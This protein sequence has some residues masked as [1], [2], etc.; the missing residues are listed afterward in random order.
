MNKMRSIVVVFLSLLMLQSCVVEQDY[1]V[2]ADHSGRFNLSMDISGMAALSQDSSMSK[3]LSEEDLSKMTANFEK[4]AGLTNIHA[5][6]ENFK[7]STGFDFNNFDAIKNLGKQDENIFGGLIFFSG[8]K[9]KVTIDFNRKSIMQSL[10][11]L[12][13]GNIEQMNNMLTLK[14]RMKFEQPIKKIKSDVATLDAAS[15]TVEYNLSLTDIFDPKK[16]LKTQVQLQ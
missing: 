6:Y 3:G 1:V 2:N 10:D 16:S 11:T 7:L 12:G 9:N 14:F 4:I 5:S 15:N 13:K 8:K